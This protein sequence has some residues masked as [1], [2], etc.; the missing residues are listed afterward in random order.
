M[1]KLKQKKSWAVY[2]GVA[3]L[4]LASVLGWVQYRKFN[5]PH[6]HV[7]LY[8]KDKAAEASRRRGKTVRDLLREQGIV[9]K[10]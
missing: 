5:E 6:F 2:I 10:P 1:V 9:L 8:Q 7:F 3:G 4:G